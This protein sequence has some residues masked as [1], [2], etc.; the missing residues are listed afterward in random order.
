MGQTAFHVY[1]ALRQ[2]CL[3][4]R[5]R[6][7]FNLWRVTQVNG[8]D[9]LPRRSLGTAAGGGGGGGGGAISAPPRAGPGESSD[10]I[11]R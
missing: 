10:L 2:S 6:F 9:H 8:L 11:G 5:R 1:D 4:C 3:L 7:R